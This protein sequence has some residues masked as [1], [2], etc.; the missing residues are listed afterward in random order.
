VRALVHPQ[1]PAPYDLEGCAA[2]LAKSFHTCL[3]G[4]GRAGTCARTRARLYARTPAQVSASL[5]HAD[6]YPHAW[7]HNCAGARTCAR[8]FPLSLS[9][10]KNSSGKTHTRCRHVR[11]RRLGLDRRIARRSFDN[12]NWQASL[13]PSVRFVQL[14]KGAGAAKP[15][16]VGYTPVLVP[17]GTSPVASGCPNE[18]APTSPWHSRIKQHTS[19]AYRQGIG[20][21][22]DF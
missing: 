19:R 1:I 14:I 3:R 2:T 13:K 22:T 5:F 12:S 20:R 18:T 7:P 15:T 16:A 6:S 17:H 21:A 4:H 9:E 11:I 10:K 8:L